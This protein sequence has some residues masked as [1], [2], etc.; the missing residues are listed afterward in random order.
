MDRKN[1]ANS[2]LYSLKET[3]RMGEYFSFNFS[4][5]YEEWLWMPVR[6]EN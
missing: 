5:S 4:M 6:A 2:G 3:M 1:F